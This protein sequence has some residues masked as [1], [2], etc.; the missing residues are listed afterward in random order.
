M[1]DGSGRA[2]PAD[3]G[4]GHRRD[5]AAGRE[6]RVVDE[7]GLQVLYLA[8]VEG[9]AS[10]FGTVVAVARA[11]HR[12]WARRRQRPKERE[13]RVAAASAAP[14]LTSSRTTT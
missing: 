11:P 1:E 6:V 9:D 3:V 12:R 14:C 7:K 10:G 13:E 2:V 8:P 5:A 4:E